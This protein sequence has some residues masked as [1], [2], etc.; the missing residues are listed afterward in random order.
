[1]HAVAG[2]LLISAYTGSVQWTGHTLRDARASRGWTQ[3]ELAEHLGAA[4]RSVAAWER[5][6]AK[7]QAKWA[8]KLDALFADYQ[9]P[10]EPARED[11]RLADATPL[12]LIGI[13]AQSFAQ[14]E[15]EN[16][17]LKEELAALRGGGGPTGERW[18]WRTEDAPSSR[19][20]PPSEA[21]NGH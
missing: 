3:A 2:T 19:R 20:E 8:A 13:L 6:E 16:E 4:P 1:M 15:A 14:L 12:E 9:H 11:R 21:T 10:T 18:A 17:S 7:P 5:G